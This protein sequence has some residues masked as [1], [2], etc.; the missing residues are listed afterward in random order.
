MR[1]GEAIPLFEQNLADRVRVLGAD[2]PDGRPEDRDTRTGPE[3]AADVLIVRDQPAAT[4]AAWKM[5]RTARVAPA[6]PDV[7]SVQRGNLDAAK[8]CQSAA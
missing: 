5:P 7:T 8:V 3:Y 6:R 1:R 4:L 2:H